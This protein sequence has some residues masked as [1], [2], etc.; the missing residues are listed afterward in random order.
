VAVFAAIRKL[1]KDDQKIMN[2]LNVESN[3]EHRKIF[4]AAG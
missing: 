4:S 2:S 3:L 1:R